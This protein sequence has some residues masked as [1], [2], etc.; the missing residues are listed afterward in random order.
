MKFADAIGSALTAV[1]ANVLRS[2]LTALNLSV[3][4][5]L[6]LGEAAFTITGVIQTEPDRGAGF[7]GFSPRVM[8]RLADKTVAAKDVSVTY[9]LIPFGN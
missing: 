1:R 6:W 4:Q 7:L 9:R 3:G 5:R 2:V 8:I